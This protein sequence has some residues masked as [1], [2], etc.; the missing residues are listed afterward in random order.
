MPR[1]DN[2]RKIELLLFAF[3]VSIITCINVYA[4]EHENQKR[5]V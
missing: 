3:I 2:M 1:G 4:Q 5:P